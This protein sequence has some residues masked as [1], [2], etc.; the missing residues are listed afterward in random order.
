MEYNL[1]AIIQEVHDCQVNVAKLENVQHLSTL[2]AHSCR[3]C[4][5]LIEDLK[6]MLDGVH[7]NLIAL[8]P[9][10]E[11]EITLHSFLVEAHDKGEA[12]ER[13]IQHLSDGG[14]PEIKDIIAYG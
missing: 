3:S 1:P 11:F 7:T 9:L 6:I 12:R 13:A 10:K 8:T 4:L 2:S 5:N 14:E